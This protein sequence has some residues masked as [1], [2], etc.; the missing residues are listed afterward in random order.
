MFED[1]ALSNN[2]LAKIFE[3]EAL[4]NV[5]VEYSIIIDNSFWFKSSR[6]SFNKNRFEV[7]VLVVCFIIIGNSIIRS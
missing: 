1:E 6:G 2:I 7:V 4:D 5:L 3:D